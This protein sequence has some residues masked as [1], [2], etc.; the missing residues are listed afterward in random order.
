MTDFPST[1]PTKVLAQSFKEVVGERTISSPVE[2]G[3]AKWRLMNTSKPRPIQAEYIYK[4]SEIDTLSTFYNGNAA[5]AFN[6]P[7][8]RSSADVSVRFTK[9]PQFRGL[10]PTLYSVTLYLE[11]S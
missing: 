2:E 6:W 10:G 9:P 5:R 4:P 8:P 11:T 7:H 1:L 3:P